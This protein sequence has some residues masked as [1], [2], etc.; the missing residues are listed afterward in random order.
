MSICELLPASKRHCLPNAAR[1]CEDLHSVDL[2][3][4]AYLDVVLDG[5]VCLSHNRVQ[6]ASQ[7]PNP[8][9]Y[10]GR[11]V[12]LG[13]SKVGTS[14]ESVA[15][16]P[17]NTTNGFRACGFHERWQPQKLSRGFNKQL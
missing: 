16:Q 8:F 2:L 4:C 11:L 1:V 5:I 9:D 3:G 6:T 7:D 15:P 14:I 10:R 17:S 12:A 13:L